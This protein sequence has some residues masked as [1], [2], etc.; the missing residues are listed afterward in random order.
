MRGRSGDV[1]L[2]FLIVEF[3][4]AQLFAEFL[5]RGILARFA[6]H[7]KIAH[8]R[9][10]QYI[11][12]AFFRRIF[13][14]TPHLFRGLTAHILDRGFH[15][16]ANDGIDIAPDV[17]HFGKFCRLDFDERRIGQPRKT[18]RDF[19][20][21]HTCRPDHQN[22]FRRNFLTQGLSHL[23]PP[24]AIAQG[25]RHRALGVILT[26]DVAVEFVDNFL[27]GHGTHSSTSMVCCW[28]V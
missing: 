5:A 19:G 20:F 8:G 11:Q 12:H 26:D 10:Q 1:D 18:A 2:D 24:P 28:L 3:T 9:R 6:I 14:L 15:Q 17:T 27:R 16:I 22:I 7:S 25:N 21:T 13:G 4:F 23:L